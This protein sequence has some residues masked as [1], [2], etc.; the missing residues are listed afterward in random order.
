MKIDARGRT[1]FDP[2]VN[3]MPLIDSIAALAQQWGASDIFFAEG[4]PPRLKVNRV[5]HEREGE[6]VT[7]EDMKVFARACGCDPE[8]LKD[9]DTTWIAPCHVR[10]RVN[11]HR[12]GGVLGA[13]LRLDRASF[14]DPRK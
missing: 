14:G 13:V 6:V 10:F 2:T 9:V 1:G 11:V 3:M 5:F 12:R 8:T 4:Q 7:T